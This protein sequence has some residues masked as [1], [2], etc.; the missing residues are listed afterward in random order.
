MSHDDLIKELKGSLTPVR[1]MPAVAVRVV[2]WLGVVLLCL[3]ASHYVTRATLSVPMLRSHPEFWIEV[4]SMLLLGISAAASALILSVP[5][6]S[7]RPALRVMA[8]GSAGVWAALLLWGLYRSC[9]VGSFA[10]VWGASSAFGVHCAS[11]LWSLSVL[12][13]VVLLVM[14]RRAAPLRFGWAGWWACIAAA[15]F[16]AVALQFMCPMRN[17]LHILIWH[18]LPTLLL[19]GLG[20]YLGRWLLRW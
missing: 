10:Q 17:P 2:Q 6:Q 12:P 3:V 14:V 15:S 19:A 11:T 13:A 9:Q 8:W 1:R 20:V 18:Y 4:M 5:G 16:S 7:I